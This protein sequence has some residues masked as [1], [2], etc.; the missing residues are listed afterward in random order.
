MEVSSEVSRDLASSSILSLPPT[1]RSRCE[2]LMF[3]PPCLCYAKPRHA[4]PL[5]CAVLCCGS[6]M[7]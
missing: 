4:M 7:L 5:C 1:C 6:A 3:L 2:L